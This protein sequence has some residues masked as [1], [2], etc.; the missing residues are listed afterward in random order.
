MLL[1]MERR[2]TLANQYIDV[3]VEEADNGRVD[4]LSTRVY[5]DPSWGW[6]IYKFASLRT[7]D[8]ELPVG[9]TL[10][11]PSLAN[12]TKA[13]SR[14]K[15]EAVPVFE[16]IASQAELDALWGTNGTNGDGCM[17]G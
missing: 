3:V 13:V 17:G 5:G 15:T 16:Y 10:R 14:E 4:L 6:I 8:Q 2:T 9:M 11:L 12:V 1:E 7:L